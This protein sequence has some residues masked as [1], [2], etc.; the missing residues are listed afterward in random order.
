MNVRSLAFLIFLQFSFKNTSH[1]VDVQS[2]LSFCFEKI[3]D[4]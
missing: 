4:S 3:E 2:A 1:K